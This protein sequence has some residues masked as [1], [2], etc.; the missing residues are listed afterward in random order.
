MSVLMPGLMQA[1]CRYMLEGVELKRLS[2]RW[3]LI[4]R[5]FEYLREV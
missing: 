5:K 4:A 1:G 2:R 3:L